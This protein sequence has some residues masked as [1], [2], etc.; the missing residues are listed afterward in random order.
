MRSVYEENGHAVSIDGRG[1]V[2]R[3]A[4]SLTPASETRS[5]SVLA[6]TLARR[7]GSH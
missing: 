5:F 1:R 2:R 7:G 3:V 6:S 4:G